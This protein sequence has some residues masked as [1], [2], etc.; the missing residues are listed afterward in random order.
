MTIASETV[1]GFIQTYMNDKV[2]PSS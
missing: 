1:S 2:I